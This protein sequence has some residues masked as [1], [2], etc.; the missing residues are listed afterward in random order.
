MIYYTEVV[1]SIVLYNPIIP[2]ESKYCD[3]VNLKSISAC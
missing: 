2:I 3:G 1:T